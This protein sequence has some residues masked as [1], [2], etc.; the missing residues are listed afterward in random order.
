MF[1]V[2]SATICQQKVE[3]PKQITLVGLTFGNAMK[4]EVKL[5]QGGKVFTEEVYANDHQD[6]RATAQARNPTVKIIGCNPIVGET[7]SWNNDDDN[8]TSSTQSPSSPL[9]N[10]GTDIGGMLGLCA[11]LFVLWLIIEYWM[12]IIPIT[13]IIA[14]LY[15]FGSKN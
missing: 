9:S 11:V 13:L 4:W 12:F 2:E 6:A 10:S 15:Y 1:S 14:I 3:S 8:N 5:Y 7:S